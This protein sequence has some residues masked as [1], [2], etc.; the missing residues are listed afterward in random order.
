MVGN[1]NYIPQVAIF[2]EVC[3]LYRLRVLC[4]QL[5]K[6]PK[7]SCSA[8][9]SVQIS[10]ISPLPDIVGI[11]TKTMD[12]VQMFSPSADG[13]EEL[14]ASNSIT[15]STFPFVPLFTTDH[16]WRFP[17]CI[18][19]YLNNADQPKPRSWRRLFEPVTSG[20]PWLNYKPGTSCR[21]FDER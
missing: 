11:K 8:L 4:L 21:G 14:S 12:T 20:G 5:A 1:S 2:G 7:T 9:Y 15:S 10:S 19:Y 3:I 17:G 13:V 6:P 16:R 18:C